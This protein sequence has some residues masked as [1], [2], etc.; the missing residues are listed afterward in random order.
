MLKY[1]KVFDVFVCLLRRFLFVFVLSFLSFEFLNRR[2]VYLVTMGIEIS[3]KCMCEKINN[4]V[5]VVAFYV[6]VGYTH[7]DTLY[8]V[9]L[10]PRCFHVST[11]RFRAGA[12]ELWR[13][14]QM[15]PWR[16]LQSRGRCCR[17]RARGGR[18][19]MHM[20]DSDG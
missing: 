20:L 1:R 11:R 4:V 18:T 9:L 8:C 17:R 10:T 5:R 13:M 16:M 15:E 12:M 6:V 7:F 3:G 19:R 14:I 2:F